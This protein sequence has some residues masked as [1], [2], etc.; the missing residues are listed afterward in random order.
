M[1][2]KKDKDN[3]KGRPETSVPSSKHRNKLIAIGVIAAI[4]AGI[5]YYT[6]KSDTNVDTAF[7]AIDSIPCETKEYLNFHIH[8]HLDVFVDGHALTV[9]ASIGIED[10]TC[11][12]WLHTHSADGIMHMESP[13]AQDFALSQFLDIW[14]TTGTNPPP[15]GEPIIYVN[16]QVV[17]TKLSETKLNAHDEIVLVYGNPPPNIPTFF[18]FPEGL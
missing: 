18:Q 1:V 7:P 13:Q 11:L 8:A 5:A 17:S 14:K 6:Y 16:G 10:N 4:I 12:Y 9:P 2:K 15:S 3:E